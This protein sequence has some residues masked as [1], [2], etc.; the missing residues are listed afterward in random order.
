MH[1]DALQD[2]ILFEAILSDLFP[3][4]QLTQPDQ[5]QLTAALHSACS[6][7]G[8]QLGAPFLGKAAQLHDTLGV[9]FGVMLVGSAGE[10]CRMMTLEA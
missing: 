8:L 5:Q 7:L 6:Q 1:T 10:G 4:T 3:D 9:R 2:I